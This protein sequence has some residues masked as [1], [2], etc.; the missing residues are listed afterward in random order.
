MAHHRLQNR[1]K[2]VYSHKT[3]LLVLDQEFLGAPLAEILRYP[4]PRL[5]SWLHIVEPLVQ[6]MLQS[7]TQVTK[8]AHLTLETYFPVKGNID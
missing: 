8:K 7:A 4:T 5:I 2:D 1:A 3:K 6:T